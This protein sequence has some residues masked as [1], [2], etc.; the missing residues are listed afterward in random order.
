LQRRVLDELVSE[1][2]VE[3]SLQAPPDGKMTLFGPDHPVTGGYPVI[4]VVPSIGLS[5]AAQLWP[6][7]GVRFQRCNL[8]K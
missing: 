6:G 5:L 2:V 4:A 8:Q 3:G 7:Q 1:G